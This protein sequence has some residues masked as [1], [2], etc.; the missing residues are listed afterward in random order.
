MKAFRKNII[1]NQTFTFFVWSII[2][3]A[4]AL[5]RQSL[6]RHAPVMILNYDL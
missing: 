6:Q 2:S 1:D 4:K 5:T 3:G